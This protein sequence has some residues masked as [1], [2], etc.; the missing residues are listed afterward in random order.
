MRVVILA[1]GKGTR[2]HPYSTVLPKPL[3]PIVDFPILEIGL[4]QL[5]HY[6]FTDVT[7]A[8]GHL[9]NLIMLLFGDGKKLGLNITYAIE[10]EPRGTIGPLANIQELHDEG[11]PFLLMNGDTLTDLDFAGF[12]MDHQKEGALVSVATYTKYVPIDLGVLDLNGGT[13]LINFREKP[14]M[15][16]LVSMGIYC[17]NPEVLD[18]IPDTGMFGFDDLMH[19]CLERKLPVHA[20]THGGI[21]LDIGRPD[22]YQ[23]AI[24]T[25]DNNRGILCP[26]E[27]PKLEKQ[28]S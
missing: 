1:G 8:V 28:T 25:F 22:D 19:R 16:F 14:K 3:M 4:R 7:I 9:A 11:R 18:H 21:W 20:H 23:A 26:W 5:R 6:G 13:R 17:M 12:A 15:S 2:L 27:T 10:D 24:E